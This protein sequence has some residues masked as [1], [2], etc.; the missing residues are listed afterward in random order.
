[1]HQ[2]TLGLIQHH[3]GASPGYT[4]FAPLKSET[5]YLINLE[6]EVVHSWESDL[7]PG[8]SVFLLKDGSLLRT[9]R[10]DDPPVFHGGGQGG[11]LRLFSWGGDLLWEFHVA[12]ESRLHHHDVCPLPN[13]NI[14]VLAWEGKSREE[15]I[16]LGR[17]PEEVGE[18][19]LWPDCVLEI[20]PLPPDG[21][22]IVWEW[23]AWDHLIQDSDP[24]LP[25]Y[26]DPAMNPGRVDIHAGLDRPIES[27]EEMERLAALGYA[28][29]PPEPD[30]GPPGD[31]RGGPNRGRADWF[32]TNSISWNP[33]LD[34]IL[35]SVRRLNEV[36]IIDHG[37]TTNEAAGSRGEIL[38]RWG[39]PA[40]WKQG[41]SKD[42]QLFGQHHA[43]WV[44]D[45]NGISGIQV[46]NNGEDRPEG[47]W[48]SVDAWALPLQKDGSYHREVGKA[49]GPGSFSWS[50]SGPGVR[51]FHS[52]RISSAQRLANGNTL[53]CSG[54]QGW[55]FEVTRG[56]AVVWEY[57]NPF[58]GEKEGREGRRGRRGPG[59]GMPGK[60][61]F[62]AERISP[63]H[64]G[65]VGR[66]PLRQPQGRSCPSQ[67]RRHRGRRRGAVLQ[68]PHRH[69]KRLLRAPRRHIQPRARGPGDVFD[70]HRP[71]LGAGLPD[72]PVPRLLSDRA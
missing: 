13:G 55:F 61:V 33:E 9:A 1:M 57:K 35:L 17:D 16:S 23:H 4:L 36:W 8:N 64:P 30:H 56:G 41:G 29:A 21:A 49:F 34:Q 51:G 27:P 42:R 31:R 12:D 11:R 18:E 25:G 32:H 14:L 69:R 37:I 45:P 24:S 5:T 10:V 50:L 19:G 72:G 54:E 65:L 62:R 47:P 6:G 68:G 22:E 53:V 67:P 15:A 63:D 59:G 39:N 71:A 20:K 66:D 3:L 28:G 60:A 43:T 26:G 46:F 2:P 7:P 52:P 38:Y 48:S 40:A 58:G 44:N 70:P